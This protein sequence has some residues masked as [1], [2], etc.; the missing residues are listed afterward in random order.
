M[1]PELTIDQ[2]RLRPDPEPERPDWLDLPMSTVRVFFGFTPKFRSKPERCPQRGSPHGSAG[3]IIRRF[4][5]GNVAA[6]SRGNVAE[7]RSETWRHPDT[8]GTSVGRCRGMMPPLPTPNPAEFHERRRRAAR[9]GCSGSKGVSFFQTT[10]TQ[11][12]W[13]GVVWKKLTEVEEFR[14]WKEGR[15]WG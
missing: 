2:P 13:V 7:I 5:G 12:E 3:G 4:P 15:G 6:S 9:G 8:A 11:Q 14:I 1:D 10:P